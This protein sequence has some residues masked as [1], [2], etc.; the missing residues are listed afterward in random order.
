MPRPQRCYR[1]VVTPST[2]IRNMLAAGVSLARW[3]AGYNGVD[4]EG[5]IEPLTR[6]N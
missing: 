6:G 4:D 2:C 5:E 3:A 1:V